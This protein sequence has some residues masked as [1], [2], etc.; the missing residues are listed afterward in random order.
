MGFL[1]RF[2]PVKRDILPVLYYR[3]NKASGSLA[4]PEAFSKEIWDNIFL[5]INR[6][7]QGGI[8]KE[9]KIISFS[10]PKVL[11]KLKGWGLLEDIFLSEFDTVDLVFGEGYA[12]FYYED[13]SVTPPAVYLFP[14]QMVFYHQKKPGNLFMC[15][16]EGKLD[17]KE[18]EVF[19]KGK[20]ID[21]QIAVTRK[22]SLGIKRKAELKTAFHAT[23]IY[24]KYL[25]LHLM[26]KK[27]QEP[28][29]K[30][31]SCFVPGGKR[32]ELKAYIKQYFSLNTE[33]KKDYPL[34]YL[35]LSFD[36]FVMKL[37]EEK[38]LILDLE[39]SSFYDLYSWMEG[40]LDERLERKAYES[41]FDVLREL[42]HR[43]EMRG[44]HLYLLGDGAF[45]E[46]SLLL[47][48]D[49]DYRGT[50]FS[51][52][53]IHF[54]RDLEEELSNECEDEKMIRDYVKVLYPLLGVSDLYGA[55]MKI[56]GMEVFSNWLYEEDNLAYLDWKEEEI[57]F[58]LHGLLEKHGL[59]SLLESCTFFESDP[60]YNGM[61][62]L[63]EKI[64][65]HGKEL[66]IFAFWDDGY[67]FGVIDR[68][69]KSRESFKQ[70]ME[71]LTSLGEV[72]SYLLWSKE[73]S[74][75]GEE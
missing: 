51:D 68:D 30:F 60:L 66:V 16:A 54:S 10:I 72:E 19:S 32:E 33:K 8:F 21:E 18:N 4:D 27:Y 36:E 71:E 29:E 43:V 67:H 17:L 47:A 73:K 20:S 57:S 9:D 34:A 42:A 49:R 28:I 3:E 11:E 24:L 39:E 41:H 38:D 6:L 63:A 52:Q 74:Q 61:G 64:Q 62:E 44:L 26:E 50:L 35:E 59:A 70:I 2:K 13:P 75:W 56:S 15:F 25:S 65:E 31:L 22:A 53:L 7:H 40:R 45:M 5:M 37:L 48:R 46:R 69:V 23:F 1:N 12:G 14:K 55:M 58:A